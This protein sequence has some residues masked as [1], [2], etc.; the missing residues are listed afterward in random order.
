M[1][2]DQTFLN[3][4]R[5]AIERTWSEIAADLMACVEEGDAPLSNSDCI[6]TIIGTPDYMKMYGGDPA[7]CVKMDEAFKEHTYDKVHAFLNKNIRL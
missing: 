7:A 4:V 1:K 5:P 3:A 2:L 6:D